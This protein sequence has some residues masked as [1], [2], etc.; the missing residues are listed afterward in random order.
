MLDGGNNRNWSTSATTPS[1]HIVRLAVSCELT[2][3]PSDRFILV[4]LGSGSR[5]YFATWDCDTTCSGHSLFDFSLLVDQ[6]MYILI[7]KHSHVGW[8]FHCVNWWISLFPNGGFAKFLIGLENKTD[9]V[10]KLVFFANW[11]S[12][13]GYI[14]CKERK[15]QPI[16]SIS[17]LQLTTRMR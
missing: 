17:S 10:P 4:G 16:W 14:S 13:H 8:L 15:Q 2:W 7:S 11:R 5:Q 9:R 6:T 3:S 12:A 1:P